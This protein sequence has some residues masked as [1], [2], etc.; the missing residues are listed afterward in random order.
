MHSARIQ[1]RLV[2]LLA[3]LVA[4]PV[5]AQG[6]ASVPQ[7]MTP[8][9]MGNANMLGMIGA[10]REALKH[11]S[12]TSTSM[13]TPRSS[14]IGQSRASDWQGTSALD[15]SLGRNA[16][17]SDQVRRTFLSGI[18][19]SSGQAVADDLDRRFGN[20]RTTFSRVV[21]PYGLRADDFADV[22]TA[23]TVMM[24]MGA[25]RQVELPQVAQ[26]QGVRRQLRDTLAGRLDD[27][28]QRQVV[29]ETMMY[30]TCVMVTVRDE[31]AQG[32]PELMDT[33][34]AAIDKGSVQSGDR[35]RRMALTSDGL[36]Q[37]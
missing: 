36:V 17:V 2:A 23:Y 12:S 27:A 25:N 16:A 22:M 1:W 24:W 8:I 3:C 30:Q 33:L 7:T 35:L 29:A 11:N 6:L 19:E 5:S 31:A 28:Q 15:F 26:V 9:Y 14:G 4:A 34:A 10:T 21:T 32:R 20:I 37:R 13:S 18:A